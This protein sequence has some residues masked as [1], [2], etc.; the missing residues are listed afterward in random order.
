MLTQTPT[1]PRPLRR[2]VRGIARVR[3]R[4]PRAR[5]PLYCTVIKARDLYSNQVM[6]AYRPPPARAPASSPHP[7][8]RRPRA[9]PA[10]ASPRRERR[11][12]SPRTRDAREPWRAA[13]TR[14]DSSV[15]RGDASGPRWSVFETTRRRRSARRRTRRR[16]AAGRVASNA[17]RVEH[18]RRIVRCGR[19]AHDARGG[20][21]R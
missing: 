19:R 8:R 10:R 21:A 15:T 7:P 6:R 11:R 18:A 3:S 1:S 16:R 2:S 4:R 17:G 9:S 12:R 5:A 20:D 14:D 13:M